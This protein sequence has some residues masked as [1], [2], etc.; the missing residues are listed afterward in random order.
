MLL[1]G[2]AAAKPSTEVP[3]DSVLEV[4]G[5]VSPWVNRAAHKLVAA[6][7]R[8][9][10]PTQG[11]AA[12]DVGASTGGFTQVLLAR[13]VTSVI[14][15]DVGHGQLHPDLVTDDR[16]DNREGSSV[17]DLT[18]QDLAPVDLVVADLSFISLRLALPPIASV[19]AAGADLVLLVKPQFEVGR[20]RLGKNGIVTNPEHRTAALR[21]VVSA[22]GGL[23]L[24]PHG[25]AHSP[26]QGTHGNIEYLLWLRQEASAKMDT[27]TVEAR[28]VALGLA[29]PDTTEGERTQ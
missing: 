4:R 6:L 21:D 18:R 1:D 22:A 26:V 27:E 24:H 15:L 5:E 11:R 2:I 13:G 23:G 19:L 17:R 28:V 16:V 9:P 10:I 25:L 12:L 29:A 20:G 8:W 7:D 3:E 14:A